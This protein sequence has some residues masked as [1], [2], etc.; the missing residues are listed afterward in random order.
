MKDEVQLL[1]D[2]VDLLDLKNKDLEF[3]IQ[4]KQGSTA[5]NVVVNY[6]DMI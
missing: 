2:R 3:K 5:D 6:P 4:Q 1:K